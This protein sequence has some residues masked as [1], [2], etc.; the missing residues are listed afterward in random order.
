MTGSHHTVAIT[1]VGAVSCLGIGREK[2]WQAAI[3]GRS[4]LE[5]GLGHVSLPEPLKDRAFG[6]SCLAMKEAMDHAGWDRLN[7]NDGFIFAT[8]TGGIQLWDRAIVQALTPPKDMALLK[9]V[10]AEQPLGRV[11]ERCRQHLDF[12]GPQSLVTSACS[13]ST[14]ALAAAFVWLRTG[15]VK[16]C[17]VG[18]TEVLSD[19]TVRGFSSLQLLSTAPC[20]PFD[21]NR[22]GI[23]LSE[24]SAFFCLELNPS[25]EIHAE[26]SGFGMSSDSY[27]STAPHPEGRGSYASM[28]GALASAK[29]EA[30]DLS[31]I[32]AHGTG[33]QLNDL[34]EGT[35]IHRLLG[36]NSVCV[37]ST[38]GIHGHA[39][40]ASGALESVL[41]VEAIRRQ[42][43]LGTHNLES[44]D[45]KIQLSVQMNSEERPIHHV[46][47][48]TAG[49]GGSNAALI[50]S[51]PHEALK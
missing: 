22:T 1:G 46:L 10:M 49:F 40:G 33:S 11:F 32:H 27:H 50:L 42:T 34:A 43:I 38:K 17:L 44:V 51:R 25:G 4:G 48:T 45:A 6:F 7:K 26:I 24:G 23:N 35:A 18:A 39:L 21:Q 14:Q 5:N 36:E 31:W 30:K 28:K 20:R 47:K 8:T 15:R 41:V 9:A 16:R 19:L 37:S 2:F 13:A 3:Q 12:S 29:I